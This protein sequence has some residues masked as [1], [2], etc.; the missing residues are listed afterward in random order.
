MSNNQRHLPWLQC[1]VPNGYWDSKAN[2]LCFLE[3]LGE[4]CG[5]RTCEDWHRVT[6]RHFRS[7][8]G[9]G[10]LNLYY[11]DSPLEAL[12]EF[13][14][15][16]P[17]KPW[18]FRSTP[19]RFWMELTN[20]RRYMAWLGVQ[21]GYWETSDWYQ[22]KKENFYENHGGG[23]LA[24]LHD[25]SPIA[26]VIEYRPA[27]QWKPWLFKSV[28]QGFWKAAENRRAYMDWLGKKLGC[29]TE[30]DWL[31]VTR[32][33]FEDNNGGGFLRNYGSSPIRA[34]QDYWPDQNWAAETTS[35]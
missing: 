27:H 14:P 29:R 35:R 9:G 1:R 6:R 15:D 21:L 31:R 30:S 2:R 18:L 24:N 19:Q 22:I 11:R 13:R 16:Y 33:D 4:E 5:F 23:M 3:W 10:L 7:H 17:W 8:G 32:R 26:A 34:L 25:D 12:L 28:P 20:R